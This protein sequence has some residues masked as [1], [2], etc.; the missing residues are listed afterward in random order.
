MIATNLDA[1]DVDVRKPNVIRHVLTEE[2]V[3]GG[4]GLRDT[5]R[6]TRVSPRHS[7]RRFDGDELSRLVDV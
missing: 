7:E 3:V 2:D 4:R 6:Q 1:V 5:N